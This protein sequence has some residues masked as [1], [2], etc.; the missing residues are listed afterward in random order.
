MV[1]IP[2]SGYK[3][4]IYDGSAAENGGFKIIVNSETYKSGGPG[5]T[6]TPD[7]SVMSGLL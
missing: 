1:S 2:N 4:H 5:G 7:Q 6:R 3:C